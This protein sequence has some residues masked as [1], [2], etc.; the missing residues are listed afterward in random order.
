MRAQVVTRERQMARLLGDVNAHD[1]LEQRMERALARELGALHVVDRV[2]AAEDEDEE[3]G[4]EAA[5]GTEHAAGAEPVP[6]PEAGHVEPGAGDELLEHEGVLPLL[7]DLVVDVAELGGAVREPERELEEPAL[8]HVLELGA[9]L[10]LGGDQVE[11]ETRPRAGREGAIP[12]RGGERVVP[13][14][15]ARVLGIDAVLRAFPVDV[16]VGV[17]VLHHRLAAE[18]AEESRIRLLGPR[19]LFSRNGTERDGSLHFAS[20]FQRRPCRAAAPWRR[21]DRARQGGA[22]RRRDLPAFTGPG[23][24]RSRGRAQDPDCTGLHGAVGILPLR[25]GH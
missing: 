23:A 19:A 22:G 3:E 8:E 21:T 18:A 10:H 16:G 24:G 5:R 12:A 1:A 11:P 2:L 7:D 4:R 20:P 14:L 17:E 13:E 6:E 9:D 15:P 25:D